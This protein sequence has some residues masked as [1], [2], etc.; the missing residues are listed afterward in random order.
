MKCK[1]RLK[2][3]NSFSDIFS[4]KMGNIFKCKADSKCYRTPKW[5]S[6][7][8]HIWYGDLGLYFILFLLLFLSEIFTAIWI[9]ALVSIVLFLLLELLIILIMPLNEIECWKKD[10]EKERQRNIAIEKGKRW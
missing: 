10:M 1:K 8:F 6:F 3:I 4:L 7:F 5:F 2:L 9:T